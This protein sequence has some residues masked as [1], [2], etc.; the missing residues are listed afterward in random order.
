MNEGENSAYRRS[1]NRSRS[2]WPPIGWTAR[3]RRDPATSIFITFGDCLDS[4]AMTR[5]G[6][7]G[8]YGGATNLLSAPGAER[9]GEVGAGKSQTF[10]PLVLINRRLARE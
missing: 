6:S 9:P 10:E 2:R 1:L 3:A 5:G 4:P 8:R 7:L